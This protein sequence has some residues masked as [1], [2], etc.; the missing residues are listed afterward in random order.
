MTI[1][2]EIRVWNCNVVLGTWLCRLM[3]TILFIYEPRPVCK[4]NIEADEFSCFLSQNISYFR[5]SLLI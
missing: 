4:L 5:W 2:I 3:I 1:L